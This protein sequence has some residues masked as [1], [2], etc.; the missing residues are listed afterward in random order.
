MKSS[1]RFASLG[2]NDKLMKVEW[3]LRRAG[4][5]GRHLL[6]RNLGL[7]SSGRLW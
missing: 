5:L 1:V 7:W 4:V 6:G 2:H 3:A